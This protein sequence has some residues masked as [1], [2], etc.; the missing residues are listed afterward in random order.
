MRLGWGILKTQLKYK[1]HEAAGVLGMCKPVGAQGAS[2][3][4]VSRWDCSC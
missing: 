3:T 1:S 4:G 2:G